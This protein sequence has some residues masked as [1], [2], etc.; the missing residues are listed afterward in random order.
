[1]L[2]LPVLVEC[3]CM[4]IFFREEKHYLFLN[5]E[6]GLG[7]IGLVAVRSYAGT[8]FCFHFGCLFQKICRDVP[9]CMGHLFG[10]LF[11]F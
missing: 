1:M 6:Q 9:G 2:D 11:S 7:Q 8:F 5:R 4:S 3:F 10:I